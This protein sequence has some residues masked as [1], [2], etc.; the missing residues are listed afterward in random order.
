MRQ[1]VETKTMTMPELETALAADSE[2]GPPDYA[3]AGMLQYLRSQRIVPPYQTRGY[4]LVELV[5]IYEAGEGT[6]MSLVPSLLQAIVMIEG[7][8][9][10]LHVGDKPYVL[11]ATGQVDLAAARAH[12]RRRLRCHPAVA[13][14]RRTT[15]VAGIR[16]RRAR[17]DRSAGI[18][19]RTLQRRRRSRRR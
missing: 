3:D 12:V 19:R 18:S 8:A 7:E 15:R 13:A 6:T 14:R 17:A 11:S 10:V 5:R 2:V 9:L 4:K 1:T 16:R